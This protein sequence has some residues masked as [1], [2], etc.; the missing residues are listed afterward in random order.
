MACKNCDMV[1]HKACIQGEGCPG[2]HYFRDHK[3]PPPTTKASPQTGPGGNPTKGTTSVTP[4]S[5]ATATEVRPLAEVLFDFPP[6]N[7]RELKLTKGETVEVYQICGEWW[8][9][10][11]EGSGKEGYFPGAYV[12]K[13]GEWELDA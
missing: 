8:F 4:G 6:E 11:I 9:G 2:N 10:A 7:D 3:K 12:K 13:I 5:V 1:V